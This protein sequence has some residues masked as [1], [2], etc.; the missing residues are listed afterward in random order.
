MDRYKICRLVD[1]D[2][3]RGW[4]VNGTSALLHLTRASLRHYSTD[5]FSS[6]FLFKAEEMDNST[7]GKP[8]SASKILSN[9]KNRQLEIYEGGSESF[10][11]EETK[12][13][14]DGTE[15]SRSK[16]NKSSFYL[17]QNL[18]EQHYNSLEQIMDH[19]VDLAGR[20]GVK[21]KARVRN[22]L[23]GWDFVDLA[24][25]RD[26]Y[27]RVASLQA[28][29]WGWVDFIRSIDAI[30]VFGR[31]F[32]D[33]IRPRDV[34]GM[35]SDWRTL[36]IDNYYLSA[37]ILDLKNIMEVF[38]HMKD[39]YLS[40]VEG[41]V[42]HCPGDLFAPCSCCHRGRA[43]LLIKKVFRRTY[44][45][46]QIF[47]PKSARLILDINGPGRLD[48]LPDDGALVFGHNISW[49]YHWA[50]DG[51]QGLDKGDPPPPISQSH[52]SA[53]SAR[54]GNASRGAGESM[55][56]QSSQSREASTESRTPTSTTSTH[57]TNNEPMANAVR[58]SAIDRFLIILS[59]ATIKETRS[60]RGR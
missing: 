7:E 21:L 57:S 23:E 52:T 5:D 48:D 32:G 45:P 54:S 15:V 35:C 56:S 10:E 12:V 6:S 1:E 37:S 4:L 58:N 11:Q 9:P 50:E 27:P 14:G 49:G 2:D 26:P 40:P 33:I 29:G 41:L 19:H 39:G 44:N 22:Y 53:T 43:E 24:K 16:T 18:V 31:K 46:V 8:F 59:R 20:S 38:G 47:V 60:I 30:T 13:T 55:A 3:K 51:R 42:W 25:G 17:F 34:A 36:P 28:V